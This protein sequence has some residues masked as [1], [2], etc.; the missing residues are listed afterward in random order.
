MEKSETKCKRDYVQFMNNNN[1]NQFVH[2]NLEWAPET[3]R[4]E[5]LSTLPQIT[6]AVNLIARCNNQGILCMGDAFPFP[7]EEQLTKMSRQEASNVIKLL[8]ADLDMEEN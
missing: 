7:R 2:V 4:D 5:K 3:F 1:Q 6:Y 8:R